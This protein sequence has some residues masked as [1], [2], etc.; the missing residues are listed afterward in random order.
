MVSEP[1]LT[2]EEATRE[3]RASPKTIRRRLAA[4]EL[5]GA[6][7]RQ[8]TRGPE[9]VMPRSSLVAAGFVTRQGAAPAALPEGEQAAADYWA[10]R[11]LD[12]EAALRAVSTPPPPGPTRRRLLGWPLAVALVLVA[13]IA[14]VLLG[15]LSSG[16]DRGDAA[17]GDPLRSATVL[18][19]TLTAPGD[20]VG[21]VGP[22][23]HD[24]L[25]EGREPV[26]VDDLSD[27][28][29]VRYVLVAGRALQR[30]VVA[31]LA[32]ASRAVL[33]L[34]SDGV[35]V[36]DT[37]L[38]PEPTDA[39]RSGEPSTE[40]NGDEVTSGSGMEPSGLAPDPDPGPSAPLPGQ[41]APPPDPERSAPPGAPAP[42]DVS[43]QAA[44]SAPTA[45][46]HEVVVAPGDSLW[47]IAE[48][49]ALD[50]GAEVTATWLRVIEANASRLVEPGNPDLLHVG[51]TIVVP[52]TP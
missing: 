36:F 51:Q 2:I 49:V 19:S 31:E 45:A 16:D 44:G 38:E 48:M 15:S 6:Y 32:T 9:W 3:F 40:P 34:P 11:A 10:R 27:A 13:L 23:A 43:A 30:P 41:P 52:T 29:E 35:M 14:G 18:L 46:G 37:T 21:H 4:G 5:E 17:T 24:A 50:A 42:G 26:P 20:P 39:P 8:G 22:A 47:T 33:R 28:S 25:P 12:A 7:K 1:L